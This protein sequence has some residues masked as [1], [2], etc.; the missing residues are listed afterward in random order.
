M[1]TETVAR[2]LD[3]SPLSGGSPVYYIYLDEAGISAPE[4]VSVVTGVLIHADRHWRVAAEF[5]KSINDEFVP[6]VLR[7]GFVFHAK[8]VWGGYRE[9]R[10]I[11]P[12]EK[13]ADY[14]G[15]VASIPRFIPTALSMCIV[16]RDAYEDS[17]SERWSKS[18]WHHFIAFWRCMARANKYVRDWGRH[19]EIATVVAE[20]V[21]DK[22]S[23]L[24]KA[25]KLPP[26]E[27]D[28]SPDQLILTDQDIASGTI[29]QTN[30]GPIDRVIDTIHFV[31]KG[32]GPLLQIADAC[33]FT[34]RRYF[35]DQ[36][37]GTEWV[38]AMLGSDLNRR[39]WQGPSSDFT[40]SFDPKH[41]YPKS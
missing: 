38:E 25:L 32:D 36:E 28:L 17:P 7:E 39:E 23:F 5:L 16:R 3:G 24:R 4:P 33:A 15:A 20:D 11:W 1:L 2:G 10:N 41:A 40:F 29:L 8:T 18:D 12:K 35:S 21:P 9:Y 22:R 6:P 31:E 34:F 30:T 26:P 13:R 19:D 37:Y 14:I 27:W